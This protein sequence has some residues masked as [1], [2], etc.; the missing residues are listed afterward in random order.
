MKNTYQFGIWA[1]RVAIIFLCLKGYRII[2]WRFKSKFGEVDIIAKKSQVIVA[3]EVKARKNKT[4]IEELLH[5]KQIQRIKKSAEFFYL[6][7]PQFHECDLRFDFVEIRRFF[8]IKH[9]KNFMS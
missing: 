5:P 9:H 8:Y 6:Q 7:N 1:E 2:A 4:A 3:V